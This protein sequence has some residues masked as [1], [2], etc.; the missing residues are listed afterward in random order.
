MSA[1]DRRLNKLYP[2]LTARERAILVLQA[3]KEGREENPRVRS[4][5]PSFQIREFNRYI[6]LMNAANFTL[7]VYVGHLAHLVEQLSLR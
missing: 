7:G 2:A 1:T 3:M 6:G 5:M 4:T